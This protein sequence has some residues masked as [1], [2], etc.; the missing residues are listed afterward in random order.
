MKYVH[1]KSA[2]WPT[3][4]FPD[5]QTIDIR[6]N[7]SVT[8][9]IE[10]DW[11]VSLQEKKDCVDEVDYS[12][13]ECMLERGK[14]KVGCS[15]NIF[16]VDE[17][18]KECETREEIFEMEEYWRLIQKSS[19]KNTSVYCLPSCSYKNFKVIEIV[20]EPI[21]WRTEWVSEVH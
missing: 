2:F 12:W 5:Q 9:H 8:L 15:L 19:F 14:K 13:T 17:H 3:E 11:F 7:K 10:T 20:E 16:N 4:F 6:P 18:Y 1:S 21:T